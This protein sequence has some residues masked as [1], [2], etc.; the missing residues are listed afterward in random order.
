MKELIQIQTHAGV[1]D[2]K[3][4][5]DPSNPI[6]SDGK[7]GFVRTLPDGV[8]SGSVIAG[9]LPS[10]ARYAKAFGTLSADALASE[11]NRTPERVALFYATDD[12]H[13]AGVA[14]RLITAAGFDPVKAG[15]VDQT[16]RLE[17]FGDLHQFG[18]LEGKLLDAQQA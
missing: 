3:V 8:S 15:G 5:V 4:V 9:L 12:E 6:T 2:G 16:L 18:G 11:A 13:A 14:E 10:G 1:L 7:G 17:V